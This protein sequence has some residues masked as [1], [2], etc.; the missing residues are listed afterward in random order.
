[1]TTAELIARLQELG[2]TGEHEVNL[3]VRNPLMPE[4]TYDH[5]QVTFVVREAL[6]YGTD[7]ATEVISLGSQ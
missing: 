1:M 2:P 3:A 5:Q 7:F 6:F 4:D